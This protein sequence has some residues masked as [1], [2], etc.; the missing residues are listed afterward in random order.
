PPYADGD[1]QRRRQLPC[2]IPVILVQYGIRIYMRHG[3][4]L[5]LSLI[6]YA[7]LYGVAVCDN[8]NNVI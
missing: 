3:D 2:M 5:L 6:T 1:L 8:R 4:I 7:Y